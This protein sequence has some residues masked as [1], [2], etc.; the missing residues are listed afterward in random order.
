LHWISFPEGADCR[1]TID[2]LTAS[3]GRTRERKGS[4]DVSLGGEGGNYQSGDGV[5][6][7]GERDGLKG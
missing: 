2:A 4:G 6:T 5:R 3:V 1:S 7:H